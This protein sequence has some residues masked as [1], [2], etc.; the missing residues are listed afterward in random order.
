MYIKRKQILLISR[1]LEYFFFNYKFFDKFGTSSNTD[2]RPD[3]EKGQKVEGEC[4][5][6]GCPEVGDMFDPVC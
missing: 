4:H 2:P 5:D 3:S 1:V 6:E